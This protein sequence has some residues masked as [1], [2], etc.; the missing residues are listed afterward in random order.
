MLYCPTKLENRLS[1]NWQDIRQSH[2]VYLKYY[3]N[4]SVELTA[5]GKKT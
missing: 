5:G 4:C 1:Q 3:Q 2:K